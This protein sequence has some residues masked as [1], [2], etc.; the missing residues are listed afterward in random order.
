MGL[1]VAH[2]WTCEEL[3]RV[4][5]EVISWSDLSWAFWWLREL[6]PRGTN[7]EVYAPGYCKMRKAWATKVAGR[8]G[9]IPEVGGDLAE[10]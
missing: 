5:G 9:L 3:E 6:E 4:L 7:P 2:L 8:R 1:C 10:E